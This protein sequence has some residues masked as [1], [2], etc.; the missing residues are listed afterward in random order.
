MWKPIGFEHRIESTCI[1]WSNLSNVNKWTNLSLTNLI[2]TTLKTHLVHKFPPSNLLMNTL[3]I[4][5]HTNNE[6]HVSIYR[7]IYINIFTVMIFPVTSLSSSHCSTAISSLVSKYSLLLAVSFQR[8]DLAYSLKCWHLACLCEDC[9]CFSF[10]MQFI[11]FLSASLLLH[12]DLLFYWFAFPG[13]L[14][15]PP[16]YQDVIDYYIDMWNVTYAL[17]QCTCTHSC[18]SSRLRRLLPSRFPHGVTCHPVLRLPIL[19]C[20]SPGRALWC[21]LLW[22]KLTFSPS[23]MESLYP[24]KERFTLRL[25]YSSVLCTEKLGYWLSDP[26]LDRQA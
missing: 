18:S 14:Q 7:Y 1:T 20:V 11:N 9:S 25:S 8:K 15:L 2:W 12:F 16:N 13:Q 3:L 10:G 21:Q 4:P 26:L 19:L 17:T 23:W 6:M 24:V 22:C 5:P